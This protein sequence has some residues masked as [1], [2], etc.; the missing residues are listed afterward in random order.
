MLSAKHIGAGIRILVRVKP[1]KFQTETLPQCAT[2][3]LGYVG[4][5]YSLKTSLI[6]TSSFYCTKLAYYCL[7][8]SISNRDMLA[9]LN[10]MLPVPPPLLF[11]WI[12]PRTLY[13]AGKS[14]GLIRMINEP[15]IDMKNG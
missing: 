4:R 1:P 15:S 3:A 9:R 8:R 14:T 13:E 2:I 12:R 7:I 6:D 10:S 11:P 5:P